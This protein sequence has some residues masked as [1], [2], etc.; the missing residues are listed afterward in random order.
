M[1]YPSMPNDNCVAH[2]PITLLPSPFPKRIYQE[3]L[4][5]QPIVNKLILNIANDLSFIEN[6][7]SDIVKTD[8]FTR[9]LLDINRVTLKEG[10]AQPIIACINRSDYMLD[11]FEACDNETLRA[12]Q[13]EVN[14]IA[15]AM[16]P[17][18]LNVSRMHSYLKSKYRIN[19]NNKFSVQTPENGSLDLVVQGLV[20]A[21]DAYKKTNSYIL[22]VTEERSYNFSDH[23]LI[24][25]AIYRTRP[26]I[27]IIRGRFCDLN[28]L[29]RLGP[30]KEL[31][32]DE[33]RK[34]VS[35]VYFR[36]GYD[37]VNYNHE[38]A[39]KARLIMERSRAVK[40]PSINFHLSGAKKFQQVLNNKEQ[41]ERFL[42][43]N[44]AEKLNK[45]LCKFWPVDEEDSKLGS[46]SYEDLVLKPQREG[47]G[48]NTFG[49]D[50]KP[51]LRNLRN[52][53]ERSQYI[54]MEMINS[55]CVR[56]CLL[57]YDK[58]AAQNQADITNE[59][60]VNELGIYG[61]ILAEGGA[62]HTNKA[63]GYLVRSKR[64]GVKEGGVASGHAGISS[65]LLVE[66]NTDD[67]D[68]TIFN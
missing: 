5:I 62:F 52:S 66:D 2:A 19:T 33:G 53:Q 28:K 57:S 25:L 49:A 11:R 46:V 37:P 60:L 39:W 36:Y 32:I 64:F 6:T 42:P 8:E 68:S 24:E 7:F 18:S 47:G 4:D 59:R 9:S 58:H 10:L 20:D 15:S 30:N 65:L 35:V 38:D 31:L 45:V 26:D 55:P 41:L 43:S 23:A 56:N 48:H 54:L 1:R 44:E 21:Y 50:I 16:A 51:F 29:L 34:E 63:A 22:F 17:H 12:R 3:C 67:L 27:P 14:T 61:S 13:V 40:C